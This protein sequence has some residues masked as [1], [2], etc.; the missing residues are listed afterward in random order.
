MR[1]RRRPKQQKEI[2]NKPLFHRIRAVLTIAVALVLCL[3]GG[4]AATV[5]VT[6][7]ANECFCFSPS[8]V[9]IHPGDTVQWVWDD[10]G[11]STTSGTPGMP[12]GLWNSG[13]LNQGATFTHTFNTRLN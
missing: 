4:S 1:D 8:P 7:G 9:T 2:M 10:E 12:D 5:I 6:I 3:R 11:H 13:I